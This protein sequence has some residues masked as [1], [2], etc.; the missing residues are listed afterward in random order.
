MKQLIILSFLFMKINLSAQYTPLHLDIGTYWKCQ[1]YNSGGVSN[2]NQ[3][4]YLDIKSESIND[5]M[6]NGLEYYIIR[7]ITK[8]LSGKL[9]YYPVEYYSYLRNDTI[10]KKVYAYVNGNDSLIYNFDL[11][12]GDSLF[13]T[14]G[15]GW[16]PD[17]TIDTIYNDNYYGV[18]RKVFATKDT[19][20]NIQRKLIEGLGSEY[21]F[22]A[23]S[24]DSGFES[25]TFTNCIK[26]NGVTLYG[27]ST[28]TCDLPLAITNIQQDIKVKVYPNPACDNIIIEFDKNITSNCRIELKTVYGTTVIKKERKFSN[29]IIDIENLPS[30]IYILAI[31][32][33]DKVYTQRIVKH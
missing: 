18:T 2:P 8:H 4:G 9:V 10:N 22:I 32:N 16:G 3:I 5:T 14:I 31:A 7:T 19:F 12:I 13:S 17:I 24:Y 15:N 28:V 1:A 29:E 21:G 25:G 33:S 23:Y 20:G 6:I 26:H 11:T 30:G 27:D